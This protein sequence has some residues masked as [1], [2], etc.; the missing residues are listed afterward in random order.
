MKKLILAV[1]LAMSTFA[2]Y[3]AESEMETYPSMM[4]ALKRGYTETGWFTSRCGVVWKYYVNYNETT[5]DPT[6]TAMK[7]RK[8]NNLLIKADN[9][10]INGATVVYGSPEI[11]DPTPVPNDPNAAVEPLDQGTV[12]EP[13]LLPPP[14]G[15][16]PM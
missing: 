12:D 5:L 3:A 7:A 14:V 4:A 9:A 2:S 1:C 11:I 8:I 15:P 13:V 16:A 10:C 6:G